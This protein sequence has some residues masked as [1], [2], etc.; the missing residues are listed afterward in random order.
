MT[1]WLEEL[2]EEPDESLRWGEPFPGRGVED[3]TEAQ[4][5]DEESEGTSASG[6]EAAEAVRRAAESAREAAAAG[7]A[8]QSGAEAERLG[9]AGRV[10]GQGRGGLEM[11][12]RLVRMGRAGETARPHS[13]TAA[14][15][16]Q[17]VGAP[18]LTVDVLDR[19]VRRDSR[20]YDGAMELY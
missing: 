3:G 20:R 9:L 2:L 1:D 10:S 6:A 8:G 11:Y 16:R 7:G 14:S 13:Q 12:R 4:L 5:W 15:Q 19:A 18:S 17:T